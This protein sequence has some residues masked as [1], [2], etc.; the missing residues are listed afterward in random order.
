MISRG[1]SE[2]GLSASFNLYTLRPFML[3]PLN[4]LKLMI[5]LIFNGIN[6]YLFNP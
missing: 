2:K 6:Q 5:M 4:M 3:S 1:E